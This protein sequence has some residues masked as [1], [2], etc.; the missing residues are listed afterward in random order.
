[1]GAIVSSSRIV[2]SEYGR[3]NPAGGSRSRP[4]AET[5]IESMPAERAPAS[6]DPGEAGISSPPGAA[7][8]P[9]RAPP[10]GRA[11]RLG[12][13]GGGADSEQREQPGPLELLG[14]LELTS[15]HV[16]E[17]AEIEVVAAGG[18]RRPHRVE[19]DPVAGRVDKDAGAVQGGGEGAVGAGVNR[20][21][22]GL[23]L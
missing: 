3:L 17:A 18:E 14:E 1:I 23:P 4:A 20:R 11:I 8:G 21:G 12:V 5:R 2:R 10:A 19:V 7:G 6:G 16:V 13:T 15:G 22:G 9:R